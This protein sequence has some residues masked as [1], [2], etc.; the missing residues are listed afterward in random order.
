[1][2][3]S[4]LKYNSE[5]K[6]LPKRNQG[7]FREQRLRSIEKRRRLIKNQKYSGAYLGEWINEPEFKSGI[8][9]KGH[10]GWLGR[11]GTAVKTNT[12]KGHASYR[13]KGAYGPVNNYSRH[14][15][16]QVV[17]GKQQLKEWREEDG[18]E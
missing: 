15:K 1:M 4:L 3:L 5:V 18:R 6:Q 11:G 9:S 2:E 10:N 16:Q 7:Y 12:R 17:D 13:H 8:L 14:D